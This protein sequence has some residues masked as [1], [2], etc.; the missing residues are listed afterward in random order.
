VSAAGSCQDPPD[1]DVG[2]AICVHAG[3]PFLES[4]RK[5]MIPALYFRMLMWVLQTAYN[6]ADAI[7]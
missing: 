3:T 6:G 2:L 4:K 7:S 5:A 1:E